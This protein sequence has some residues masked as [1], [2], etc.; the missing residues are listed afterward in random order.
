MPIVRVRN[1]LDGRARC[2][3]RRHH[4]DLWRWALAAIVRLEAVAL[5]AETVEVN[6]VCHTATMDAAHVIVAQIIAREL[7]GRVHSAD[8][9][10]LP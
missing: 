5:A 7:E 2:F 4:R 10:G 3:L 8:C 9:A 6:A 1:G